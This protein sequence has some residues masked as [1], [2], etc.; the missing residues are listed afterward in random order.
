MTDSIVF[1]NGVSKCGCTLVFNSGY[2]EYS[3]VHRITPCPIHAAASTQAPFIF[4]I[5][6]PDGGAYIEEMCVSSSASNLTEEVRCLNADIVAGDPLY[7]VV[8]LYR[9]AA[10]SIPEPSGLVGLFAKRNGTWLE[11]CQG[12]SFEHPDGVRLYAH[13]APSMPADLHPDTKKL[14]ADFSMALAEKLYKA[15]LKYGHSDGWSYA[16]WEIECQTAFHEHVEKGDP[17]DVAAYCAFMWFH[18]WRTE[19]PA[20]SI[21]DVRDVVRQ[22][23]AEWSQATFGNVGPVGPLK[24]LAK[25]AIEAANKPD[26]LSEWADC[27]LLL[28][29]AQRRAGITDEQLIQAC[30][31]K[32]AVNKVRTWPEPK[33]GEPRMHVKGGA[34]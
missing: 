4:G 29:D 18:N 30:A 27:Q 16:N 22:A 5:S 3:D 25:E 26:D 13:P 11:L 2:G 7:E 34:E 23:H 12:D 32:L 6:D 28:W 19:L 33:D 10:P 20:P 8:P 21:P 24:H 9:K 31:D 1:V 17:R 15:Q 14:V